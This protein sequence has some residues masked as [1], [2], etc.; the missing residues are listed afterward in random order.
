[1]PPDKPRQAFRVSFEPKNLIPIKI[2]ESDLLLDG[3]S[4][5]SHLL[6]VSILKKADAPDPLDVCVKNIDST[7]IVI[8]VIMGDRK[9][10]NA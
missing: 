2:P 5:T 9:D 4:E 8:G 1:M 7:G 3:T 10:L 6:Q